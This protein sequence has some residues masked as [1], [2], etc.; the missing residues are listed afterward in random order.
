MGH[1]ANFTLLQPVAPGR[2]VR[3]VSM[4]RSPHAWT[5]SLYLHYHHR[6]RGRRRLLPSWPLAFRGAAHE[7]EL[8]G[9]GGAR[10]DVA[11]FL[12]HSLFVACPALSRGSNE[13][14]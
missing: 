12:R 13:T 10:V 1:F 11:G 8:G 9:A 5:L 6:A 2:S 14:R 4:V 7:R 3:Y